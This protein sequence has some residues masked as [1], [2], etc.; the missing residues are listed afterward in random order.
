M[1]LH[2]RT[3]LLL[4]KDM[5]NEFEEKNSRRVTLRILGTMLLA[6]I[7]AI[8]YPAWG[9]TRPKIACKRVGQIVI[10][11]GKKYTCIKVNKK[12]IWDKGSPIPQPTSKKSAE[13][14]QSPSSVASPSASNLP[15]PTSD[16]SPSTSTAPRSPTKVLFAKSIEIP[17]QGSVVVNGKDNLGRPLSVVFTRFGS[18]LVA[19]EAFCTHAGCVVKPQGQELACPCHYSIF[20]PETGKPNNP[21][22]QG[23]YPLPRL[24]A[25]EES[26]SIYLVFP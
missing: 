10:Y 16:A 25:F 23:A 12:L 8:A 18:N 7:P 21:A 13:P 2:F 15:S 24:D 17:S 19:L 4:S 9:A 20:D 3:L 26:G 11:K 6:A 5:S 1:A 22:Q 14:S